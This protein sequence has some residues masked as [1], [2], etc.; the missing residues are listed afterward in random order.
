M[1]CCRA[2]HGNRPVIYLIRRGP[3]LLNRNAVR[4]CQHFFGLLTDKGL[5]I[6]PADKLKT[7]FRP[8][9]LALFPISAGQGEEAGWESGILRT[10]FHK[11]EKK[12]GGLTCLTGTNMH[13]SKSQ[14]NRGR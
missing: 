4:R 11:K 8:L 12:A 7:F 10:L 14:Q 13:L 3:L 9:F 6:L 5:R 1:K 2:L